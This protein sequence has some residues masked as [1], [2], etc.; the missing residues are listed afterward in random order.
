MLINQQTNKKKVMER[1]TLTIGTQQLFGTCVDALS[2]LLGDRAVKEGAA[3]GARFSRDFADGQHYCLRLILLPRKSKPNTSSGPKTKHQR[4]K[5]FLLFFCRLI[6]TAFLR[7]L[8]RACAPTPSS[9]KGVFKIIDGLVEQTRDHPSPD[10]SKVDSEN[11]TLLDHMRRSGCSDDLLRE[12]SL[13]ILLAATDT[14]SSL[15]TSCIYELAGRDHLWNQLRDEASTLP[16][17]TQITL[18][19]IRQLKFLRAIVNETLR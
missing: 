4:F 3:D 9:I 12:E 1:L 6:P 19:Q 14:T 7:R 16:D 18:E 17:P 13:N 15:L 8:F 11:E 2:D 10:L 5:S